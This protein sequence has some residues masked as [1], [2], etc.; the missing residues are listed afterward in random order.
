MSYREAFHGTRCTLASEQAGSEI[1]YHRRQRR[2]RQIEAIRKR[3]EDEALRERGREQG[4]LVAFASRTLQ[5]Y[6]RVLGLSLYKA[7]LAVYK[8]SH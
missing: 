7:S 5:K 1:L 6:L 8:T 4:V 3:Q 2:G